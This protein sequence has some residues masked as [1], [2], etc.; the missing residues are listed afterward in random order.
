MVAAAP[1]ASAGA[2]LR[3]PSVQSELLRGSTILGAATVLNSALSVL[4]TFVAARLL[5]P[6]QYGELVALLSIAGLFGAPASTVQLVLAHHVASTGY[7]A[8]RL[9]RA[10]GVANLALAAASL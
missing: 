9:I 5:S 3:S 6:S 10:L 7:V 4:Y 8:R 1:N 2:T